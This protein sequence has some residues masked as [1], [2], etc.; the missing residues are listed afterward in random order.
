MITSNVYTMLVVGSLERVMEAA[1]RHK[2]KLHKASFA[3]GIGYEF[4]VKEDGIG[5]NPFVDEMS[6]SKD[7]M[8]LRL[9]TVK[10]K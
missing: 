2:V 7:V 9:Y 6:R 5:A 1:K 8:N 4:T 3:P 10:T